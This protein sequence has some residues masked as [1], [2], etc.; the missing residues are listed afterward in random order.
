MKTSN[1]IKR[2]VYNNA[3]SEPPSIKAAHKVKPPLRTALKQQC[4]KYG[5]KMIHPVQASPA[6]A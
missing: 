5:K 6:L 2:K 3:S 4:W 1:K